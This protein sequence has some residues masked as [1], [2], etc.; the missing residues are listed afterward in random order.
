MLLPW[1]TAARNLLPA[2]PG[3]PRGQAGPPPA[4]DLVHSGPRF[5]VA[6]DHLRQENP[7]STTQA[8]SL[9]STFEEHVATHLPLPPG[10]GRAGERPLR[11][12]S[13]PPFGAQPQRGRQATD[14]R[15]LGEEPRGW[16]LRSCC[17][18]GAVASGFFHATSGFP[19]VLHVPAPAKPCLLSWT[20]VFN[21]L[22]ARQ[23][24]DIFPGTG[25]GLG[26]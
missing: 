24:H 12:T 3:G 11:P 18:G 25:R 16:E 26:G 22:F 4:A 20:Q 15:R 13:N 2:G 6:R 8:P 7:G 23:Q 10:R 21:Y 9:G 14:P 1:T 17:V 19:T 5:W